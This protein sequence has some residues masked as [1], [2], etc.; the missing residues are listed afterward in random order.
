MAGNLPGVYDSFNVSYG[1]DKV[2]SSCFSADVYGNNAKRQQANRLL[3]AGLRGTDYPWSISGSLGEGV[4]LD[5]DVKESTF[6]YNNR[7]YPTANHI[8]N[9]FDVYPYYDLNFGIMLGQYFPQTFD[10]SLWETKTIQYIYW[11]KYLLDITNVNGKVIT[12]TFRFS[13]IDIYNLDFR[14]V[15]RFNNY[16]MKLNRITDWDVNGDGYSKAEFTLKN[17]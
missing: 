17:I 5:A 3:I 2:F 8:D 16:T 12:G 9:I 11:G 6:G 4:T 10:T 7:W 14:N 15:Y 1:N 13:I